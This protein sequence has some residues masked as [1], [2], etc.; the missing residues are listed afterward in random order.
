[1]NLKPP[2]IGAGEVIGGAVQIEDQAMTGGAP[3]IGE[4]PLIGG[5][6]KIDEQ[7]GAQSKAKDYREP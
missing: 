7:A 2:E 5:V 6:I 3:P 1:M 4:E